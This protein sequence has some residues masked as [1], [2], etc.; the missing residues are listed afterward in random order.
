MAA[1]QDL[2]VPIDPTSLDAGTPWPFEDRI[3][4]VAPPTAPRDG[5]VVAGGGR[6]RGV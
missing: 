1:L 5:A 4:L 6:G 3:E 2:G